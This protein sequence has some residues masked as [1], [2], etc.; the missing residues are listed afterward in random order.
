MSFAERR[1]IKM[2]VATF[3]T[4]AML[5][6]GGDAVA[7]RKSV[8]SHVTIRVRSLDPLVFTG[9]VS[10]KWPACADKRLV[11]VFKVRQG[12]DLFVGEEET[13][14]VAKH[15]EYRY[16]LATA[17]RR[18]RFYARVLRKDVGGGAHD[19]IC[20]GDVSRIVTV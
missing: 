3:V 15:D 20:A 17:P 13:R 14:Y 1:I 16:A 10:S 6:Q 4:A 2:L 12:P 7:H 5:F 18:G 11:R 8:G 9:T 19:H